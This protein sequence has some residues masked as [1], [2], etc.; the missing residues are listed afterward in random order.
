[1]SEI[2]GDWKSRASRLC[3]ETLRRALA[4]LYKLNPQGKGFKQSAYCEAEAEG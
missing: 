1:M 2:P 4:W 3:R